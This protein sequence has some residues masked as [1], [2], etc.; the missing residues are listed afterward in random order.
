MGVFS[1]FLQEKKLGDAQIVWVSR[2][3]ERLTPTDRE[4]Y[5][6]RKRAR[7][8]E[9]KY[10]ELELAK[11]HSG[12]GVSKQALAKA[13][14]DQPLPRKVRSKITAAINTILTRRGQEAATVEQIFGKVGVAK[15]APPKKGK[16]K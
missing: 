3:L 6:K 5:L 2:R 13:R 11:P 4:L 12:R 10:E 8:E 9:K 1:D 7:K 15:G 14:A 16:K